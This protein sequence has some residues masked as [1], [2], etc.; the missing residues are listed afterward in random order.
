MNILVVYSGKSSPSAKTITKVLQEKT[1]HNIY[2]GVPQGQNIRKIKFDYIVNV[3]NSAP[4]HNTNKNVKII[5]PPNKIAI[6]ANKRLARMRFKAKKISAPTLWLSAAEIPD[7]EFPVVGRTTYHMKAQ[8]F[9]Y[10][11]NKKEAL[12]AE[13]RGATHFLRFISN[14][15][16]Y[17]AHVFS[18]KLCMESENDYIIAK[19]S[20]K[21][22]SEITRSSIIKNHDSGYKFLAP[23]ASSTPILPMIRDLAK[24]T[25]FK[26]GLHYGG[27]DIIY[28][29]TTKK[30][31]VLE[32]NS[33][34]CL[35]DEHTNTAEVYAEKL[36]SL[37]GIL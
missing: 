19:L 7:Y 32:I 25:I 33:T 37:M 15:R 5:N 22:A 12:I 9:W 24:E 36:G 23:S 29:N 31:Y 27:V 20:E 18:T 8:G 14:T 1:T 2:C 21:T 11:K 4:F 30:A 17:R 10:C 6:S 35:T 13:S 3:G 26:F 16:E 28:S 34:P